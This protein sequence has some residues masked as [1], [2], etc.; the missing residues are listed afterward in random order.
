MKN[1][2]IINNLKKSFNKRII[3]EDISLTV[4][5]GEIVGVIGKNGAGKSTLAKLISGILKP[6]SGTIKINGS[7]T[8]I[9]EIGTG[10][11]PDFTGLEN[12]I[13]VARMNGFKV[14]KIQQEIHKVIEFSE[15]EN[16]IN[17]K[18]KTYSNGMY[19]RLAFSIF[20]FFSSD[21]LIMD[22]IFSVGDT[23]F[24]SKS[25]Q[26]FYDFKI[27]NKTIVIVSH[28]FDDLLTICDR[29]IYLDKGKVRM[30]SLEKREVI[31]LYLKD[32]PLEQKIFDNN[33]EYR[34]LKEQNNSPD[35]T[36]LFSEIKNSYFELIGLKILND[37][38]LSKL[39]WSDNINIKITLK[40]LKSTESIELILKFFDFKDAIIL[41]TSHAYNED[42]F[43][44][45]ESSG[46]YSY[47]LKIP[48]RFFNPGLI[49]I[50]L[51]VTENLNLI[52]AW[53]RI[54]S[55]EIKQEPWMVN[56]SWINSPA[57]LLLD[58]EWKKE[59]IEEKN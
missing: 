58:L 26:V 24:K 4:N 20:R 54:C 10:F 46:M 40:K 57:P 43:F 13:M 5:S 34:Y 6:S 30:D 7:I 59:K 32:Y 44:E 28:N 51:L 48:K 11:H 36:W 18:V 27:Q 3:L 37:K 38:H 55:F 9:L 8:S 47:L 42:Y 29:I 49:N 33:W 50:T 12:I 22:E 23:K 41:E 31:K 16:E 25:L 14:D 45:N 19:L 21:I 17:N 2:I 35:N 53:H 52:G 1:S 39:L 56:K 15:L